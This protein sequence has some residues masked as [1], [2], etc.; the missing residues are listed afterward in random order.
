MALNIEKI[1]S[2]MINY[3]LIETASLKKSLPGQNYN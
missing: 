1:N 2:L 3:E